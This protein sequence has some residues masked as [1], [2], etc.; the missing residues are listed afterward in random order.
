MQILILHQ[1]LNLLPKAQALHAYHSTSIQFLLQLFLQSPCLCQ[2]PGDLETDSWCLS[3]WVPIP[4]AHRMIVQT[5]PNQDPS[6]D[7]SMPE[8]EEKW[9]LPLQRNVPRKVPF[10]L[11]LLPLKETLLTSVMLLTIDMVKEDSSILKRFTKGDGEDMMTLVRNGMMMNDMSDMEDMI[12][13]VRSEGDMVGG[14]ILMTDEGDVAGGMIPMTDEGGRGTLVID[15]GDMEGGMI[16]VRRG[17][18]DPERIIIK[19][20]PKKT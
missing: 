19:N 12:T 2:K 20:L 18:E 9:T 17:I 8:K 4:T 11:K 14:M 1:L 6:P 3:S 5:C 13:L 10:S 16:Q 7:S 15:E